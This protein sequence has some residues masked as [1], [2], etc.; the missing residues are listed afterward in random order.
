MPVAA[1]IGDDVSPP[2]GKGPTSLPPPV[3]ALLAVALMAFFVW[4]V[5]Q[6]YRFVKYTVDRELIADQRRALL[7]PEKATSG[8]D[9]KAVEES[10]ADAK[11][12]HSKPDFWDICEWTGCKDCQVT[13]MARRDMVRP[14]GAPDSVGGFESF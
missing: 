5:Y 6:L 8:T 10:L 11:V 2:A 7:D 12:T 9:D 1:V 3:M 13:R 4:Y 14:F